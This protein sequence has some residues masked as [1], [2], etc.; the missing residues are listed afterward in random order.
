MYSDFVDEFLLY[1]LF[2]YIWL[3]RFPYEEKVD[4]L[5]LTFDFHF[6]DGFRRL[7]DR[8][9]FN[10]VIY[11][12]LS[13]Y[14][15]G[16]YLINKNISLP[17]F[18]DFWRCLDA[19][20]SYALEV[21]NNYVDLV[22]D[23]VGRVAY[24]DI[25]TGKLI[26]PTKMLSD[27]MANLI[28]RS[29]DV[30]SLYDPSLGS[31]DFLMSAISH[32]DNDNEIEIFGKSRNRKEYF[33]SE[34]QLMAKGER[35]QI[36]LGDDCLV[37]GRSSF[38]K[39]DLII[40][41]P[42]FSM[43]LNS[44]YYEE[45]IDWGKLPRNASD[46]AFL[47]HIVKSLSQK[48]EALVVVSMGTLNSDNKAHLRQGLLSEGVVKKI[49]QL[50]RN[51]FLNTNIQTSILFLDKSSKTTDIEFIDL[52]GYFKDEKIRPEDISVKYVKD[53]IDLAD[54]KYYAKVGLD[55]IEDSNYDLS[56]RRYCKVHVDVK[57]LDVLS[58]EIDE[59]EY[60]WLEIKSKLE[61]GRRNIGEQR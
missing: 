29:L 7:I 35:A 55:R 15:A 10:G 30:N 53:I 39:A 36:E 17:G 2:I 4:I 14:D 60:K 40:T 26:T 21:D 3:D 37:N 59:L 49:I 20:V 8:A 41:N 44:D 58:S 52:E 28:E 9:S 27:F 43:L 31:A 6:I 19:D 12:I 42:P 38:V 46:F 54:S 61:Q 16:N 18:T 48:G 45:Y 24:G 13:K 34:I 51:V 57:N 33:L 22:S 5:G 11:E 1:Y 47:D 25:K 56:C 32:L 50:P 23:L